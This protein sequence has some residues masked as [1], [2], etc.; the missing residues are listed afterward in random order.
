MNLPDFI[1]EYLNE[2]L[3]KFDSIQSI[4]LIGSRIN[5]NARPDSDWDFLIFADKAV[6]DKLQLDG[7]IPQNDIS[8]MVVIDNDRFGCPWPRKKDEAFE[9]GSLSGW[10]W[11]FISESQAKY[12]GCKILPDGRSR[13]RRENAIRVM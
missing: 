2:L 1:N 10:K 6:H 9:R 3:R 7:P 5:G 4:W 11:S 13:C 12:E 8:I